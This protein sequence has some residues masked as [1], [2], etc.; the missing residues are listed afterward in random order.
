MVVNISNQVDGTQ[1]LWVA[2]PSAQRNL[3]FLPS[4]FYLYSAFITRIMLRTADFT[5]SLSQIISRKHHVWRYM[6]RIKAGSDA[7]TVVAIPTPEPKEVSYLS[8]AFFVWLENCG[9]RL[10]FPS[11]IN[12]ARMN[13]PEKLQETRDL[14][15]VSTWLRM[16]LTT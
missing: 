5:P 4:H 11:L 3:M 9:S 10:W 6:K 15:V 14:K 7:Y 12:S 8:I 1:T 2:S 16:L 13:E